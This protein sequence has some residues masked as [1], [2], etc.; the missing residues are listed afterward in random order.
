MK[1]PKC[2]L[3]SPPEALRCDC[4]WDFSSAMMTESYLG[5]KVSDLANLASLVTDW[6]VRSL[7]PLS[8]LPQLAC[9]PYRS[10]RQSRSAG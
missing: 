6:V 4:E 2:G 7:T 10:L 5:A 3:L 1:C 8:H 9:L